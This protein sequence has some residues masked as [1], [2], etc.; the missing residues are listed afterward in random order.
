MPVIHNIEEGSG[1][2]KQAVD[3]FKKW[4]ANLV[5][6]GGSTN[7]AQLIPKNYTDGERDGVWGNLFLNFV[8]ASPKEHF[9]HGMLFFFTRFEWLFQPLRANAPFPAWRPHR[10]TLKAYISKSGYGIFI[11]KASKVAEKCDLL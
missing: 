5:R 1:V 4:G 11:Q 9:S 3:F 10:K 2:S 7:K 8:G 6:A